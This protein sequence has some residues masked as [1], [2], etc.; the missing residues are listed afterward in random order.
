MLLTEH[1]MKLKK[2]IIILE[3]RYVK[4]LEK[5][6]VGILNKQEKHKNFGESH[7]VLVEKNSS[8]SNRADLQKEKDVVENKA[9]NLTKGKEVP[10]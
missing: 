10:T 9:K 8:D 2:I 4:F 1:E 6:A 7:G 3:T 5:G